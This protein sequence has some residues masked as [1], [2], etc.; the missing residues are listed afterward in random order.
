[1]KK[2]VL[3]NISLVIIL[4]LNAQDLIVTNSGDTINCKITSMK[5]DLIYFTFKHE[6]E[7]R[8]TL[9]PIKDTQTHQYNYFTK[10]EVAPNIIT[11]KGQ[12]SSWRFGINAGYNN[13]FGGKINTDM[14]SE[15]QSY[16]KRIKSGVILSGDISYFFSEILGIGL[17][18]DKTTNSGSLANIMFTDEYGYTLYTGTLSQHLDINY[19]APIISSRFLSGKENKNAFFMNIGIGLVDYSNHETLGTYYDWKFNGST[20]GVS[21]DLG[22]DFTVS[23]NLALGFQLSLISANLRSYNFN[24]GN[25]ITKVTFDSDTFINLSHINL[26]FGIRFNTSK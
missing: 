22:Y 3:L 6:N 21:Y 10:A 16:Q 7:V 2:I 20:V 19:I 26:T 1:M 8:N 12:Y 13:Y 17:R 11:Y 15:I 24:D 18:F 14:D 4:H 5:N 23:K 9:L 25:S